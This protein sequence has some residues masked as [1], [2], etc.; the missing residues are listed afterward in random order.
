MKKKVC[1]S[2]CVLI[3]FSITLC[4]CVKQ[5]V[6][7]SPTAQ[8][9][10]TGVVVTQT[11]IQNIKPT[12][13][14]AATQEIRIPFAMFSGISDSYKESIAPYTIFASKDLKAH[15]PVKENGYWDMRDKFGS[16]TRIKQ[17]GIDSSTV[18]F[19]IQ[20]IGAKAYR[21]TVSLGALIWLHFQDFKNLGMESLYYDPAGDQ[22]VVCDY[23]K[24]L[25][26]IYPPSAIFLNIRETGKISKGY[27]ETDKLWCTNLDNYYVL[28]LAQVAQDDP[29]A[30]ATAYRFP[31][32]DKIIN[33]VTECPTVKIEEI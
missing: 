14:Q 26:C 6:T 12:E 32:N 8:P 1:F 21:V 25:P 17:I 15:F 10:A 3:L 7:A 4:S 5:S 13:T 9:S 27:D 23:D 29:M 20:H 22:F 11:P 30:T 31:G 28:R 16:I 18:S 24:L 33:W 19:T 2:L